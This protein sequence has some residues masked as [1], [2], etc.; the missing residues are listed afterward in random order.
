MAKIYIGVNKKCKCG[1]AAKY[2]FYDNLFKFSPIIGLSCARCKSDAEHL[3]HSGSGYETILIKEIPKK[4]FS[5][6]YGILKLSGLLIQI[7]KPRQF[8]NLIKNQLKMFGIDKPS[9]QFKQSLQ[10]HK[11]IADAIYKVLKY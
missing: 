3:G 5:R 4:E 10:N 2:L 11:K 9:K 1:K 7:S 6:V 8:R